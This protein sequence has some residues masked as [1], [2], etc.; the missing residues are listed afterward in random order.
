MAMT[1]LVGSG[2]NIIN[3]IAD[4]LIFWKDWSS[5]AKTLLLVVM[6]L[7]FFG[8]MFLKDGMKGG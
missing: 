3:S 2:T 4:G 6:V 8:Y 5:L 7:L 1:D